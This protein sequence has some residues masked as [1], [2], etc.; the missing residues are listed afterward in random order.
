MNRKITVVTD[1]HGNVVGTHLGHG[2]P[3]PATG[4]ATFL[5]AGPKQKV[6]K[7]QFEVPHL[8]RREDIDDFHRRLAE[9]LRKSVRS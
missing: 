7:I 4:N 9:H 3:D 6:H 5:V 8:T 1:E 2:E